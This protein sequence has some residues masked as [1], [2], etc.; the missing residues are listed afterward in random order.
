MNPNPKVAIVHDY[1]FQFGGAEKCIESW[2]E[3]YPEAKIYTSFYLPDKFKSSK[4]IT[5]SYQKGNI[6]TSLVQ[7]FFKITFFQKFQKHLFF[8][9]PLIFSL[10][11]VKN[12]DLVIISSSYCAKNI[13]LKNNRKS[14]YYCY[15]PTRFLYHEETEVDHSTINPL[16]RIFLPFLIPLLRYFDQRAVKYLSKKRVEFI[17]ISNYIKSKIKQ[18]YKLDSKVIYPPVEIDSFL[19][20]K[21]SETEDFYFT[22]GRVSFHKKVDI[23]IKAC[24]KTNR[25]L[26]IAGVSAYQPEYEK[27]QQ[28]VKNEEQKF[29][30]K[31][32]LVQFLGRVSDEQ[33]ND[34]L[35]KSKA[36]LFAAKE[37][38]GIAPV[39]ALA[40]GCPVIAFGQGGALEYILEFQ[41]GCLFGS[42]DE[43]SLIAA[44]DKFEQSGISFDE[45]EIKQSSAK[46]SSQNFQ[47][48]FL[49]DEQ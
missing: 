34:L 38:F 14:L 30:Q 25:K 10:W 28:I 33:R 13:K 32:G 6:K 4:L 41:N 17:A 37:D 15:T 31:K 24:L 36:F 5:T 45:L 16:L 26:L 35:T 46:F 39:E 2:L 21:R 7:L 47:K 42:Q 29:P 43:D 22:F 44:M 9:Y 19:T 40:A 11:T 23:L 8:L 3:I 1:L 27:L 18:H 20:L 49:I 48:Q 12:Y